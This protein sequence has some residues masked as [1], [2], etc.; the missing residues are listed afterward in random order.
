DLDGKRISS[1]TGSPS[2]LFMQKTL[3]N[4]RNITLEDGPSA[5]MALVK[6]KVD[7]FTI[8]EMMLRQFITRLGEGANIKVLP[9]GVGTEVWGLAVRKGEPELRKAVNAA[10]Q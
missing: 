10:L 7:G 3:P 2:A 9:S 5:F 4:A 8:G 1:I 6:G